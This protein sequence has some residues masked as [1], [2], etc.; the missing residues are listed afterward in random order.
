MMQIPPAWKKLRK[1]SPE[2]LCTL[3]AELDSA[4]LFLAPGETVEQFADR[5]AVL[6]NS[7]S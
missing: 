5:L 3:L 1:G 2:E 6:H 7:R 4:G